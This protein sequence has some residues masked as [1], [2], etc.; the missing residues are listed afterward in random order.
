MKLKLKVSKR[1]PN[2]VYLYLGGKYFS[3]INKNLLEKLGLESKSELTEDELNILLN[4]I[5]EEKAKNYALRLLA[6]RPRSKKELEERL[7]NKGFTKETIDRVLQNLQAGELLSDYDY[8]CSIVNHYLNFR[9]KGKKKIIYELRRRGISDDVITQVT[10]EISNEDEYQALKK[11]LEKK[12]LYKIKD[13][14]KLKARLLRSGYNLD[15]I[16]KVLSEAQ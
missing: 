8:A 3:L 13:L 16:N 12:N 9:L 4:K 10:K 14:K 1:N 5:S 7:T 2:K 6:F 11:L 15:V